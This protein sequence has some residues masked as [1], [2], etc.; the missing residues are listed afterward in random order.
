MAT[1][2]GYFG[3]PSGSNV[4]F[5]NADAPIISC[6]KKNSSATYNSV[7]A[8]YPSDNEVVT[9]D[10]DEYL[11]GIS[12]NTDTLCN[13]ATSYNVAAL[14]ICDSNGSNV[15]VLFDETTV[16]GT[17]SGVSPPEGVA[18]S[19]ANKSGQNWSNLAGKTIA[20]KKVRGSKWGIY[21]P[22]HT[23]I[24]LT[25]AYLARSVSINANSGGTVTINNN[26]LTRGQTATVTVTCNSGYRVFSITAQN[27]TL[28]QNQNGTYTFTMASPAQNAII[29]VTF[30]KANQPVEVTR[31]AIIT[32]EVGR[33]Y[34]G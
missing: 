9:L 8:K 14:S 7:S 11:T 27:G 33:T 5:W 31:Y 24:T 17:P 32:A 2:T 6:I 10:G 23:L 34:Y 15:H 30:G 4:S 25:T 29:D 20:L 3:N 13:M 21:W 18:P 16:P 28:T 1:K 19:V 26:S 12:F 22:H